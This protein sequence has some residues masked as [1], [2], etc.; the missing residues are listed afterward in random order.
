MTMLREKSNFCNLQNCHF[1]GHF[2]VM[3]LSFGGDFAICLLFVCHFGAIFSK[4][5]KHIKNYSKND[6]KNDNA[7]GKAQ[8]LRP[9]K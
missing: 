8:L 2:L 4:I 3:F 6:R 5:W 7:S 9:A 1:F